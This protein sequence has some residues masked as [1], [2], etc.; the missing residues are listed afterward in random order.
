[1]SREAEAERYL[2][3]LPQLQQ[4]LPGAVI[5]QESGLQSL[6]GEAKLRALGTE[7]RLLTTFLKGT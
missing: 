5:S 3:T 2:P 6:L 4:N 7:H 1:M